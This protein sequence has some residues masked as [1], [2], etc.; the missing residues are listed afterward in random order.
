[1]KTYL[2]LHKY[3]LLPVILLAFNALSGPILGGVV[4]SAK[5]EV[6]ATCT[7]VC[8]V[9]NNSTHRVR[10]SLSVVSM[11]LTKELNPGESHTFTLNGNTFDSAFG[12]S[13]D[14]I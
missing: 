11:T 5:N 10:A 2:G 6:S 8:S 4:G 1:M 7:P 3:M 13:V 9:K 12:I 14:Y